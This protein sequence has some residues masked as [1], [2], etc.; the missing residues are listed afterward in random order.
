MLSL[1]DFIGQS[2]NRAKVLGSFRETADKD[3]TTKLTVC[4]PDVHLLERGINDKFFGG[5][6]EHEERFLDFLDFMDKLRQAEGDRLEIIQ[7]GD[8]YDLWK[9]KG[10]SNLI[11]EAYPDILGLIDKVRTTYLVGNHDFEMARSYKSKGETFRRIATYCSS[12]D[13]KP[14][15]IYQHGWQADIFNNQERWTGGIGKNVT[16]ILGI[17]ESLYPDIDVVLGREWDSVT[18]F[19]EHYNAM[20]SPTQNPGGFSADEYLRYYIDL[21][22]KRN[23]VGTADHPEP[24]DLVL[25][26]VGHTHHA[27]SEA[28]PRSGRT[29]Y[30]LDCGSWVDGGH[31]IGVISGRDMAVCQWG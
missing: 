12:V 10:D 5:K 28:I 20:L 25:S 26:V 1:D 23:N 7:I 29:Y 18:A 22:E 27:R 15:T 9:A 31:E 6:P 21:M 2:G 14:R 8:L 30:L 13:E 3:L 17:A 16:K 19:F 4:I 11:D 24:L